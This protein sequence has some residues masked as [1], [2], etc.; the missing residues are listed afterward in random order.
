ME[1]IIVRHGLS[2]ANKA[3]RVGDPDS[4][5]TEEGRQQALALADR[6]KDLQIEV[7]YTSTMRRSLDTAAPYAR[8]IDKKVIADPRLGEVRF[9]TLEGRPDSEA[10]KIVGANI[11]DLFD[12]YEYDFTEWGGETSEQVRARVQEFLDDLKKQP[13]K[14]VLIV[15]HGGIIRWLHYLITGEKISWLPNAEELHLNHK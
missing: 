9:G 13:Y 14:L 12:S 4:P 1:L 8:K 10:V 7:I 3:Q 15:C 11:R 6:L 2:E 5:L